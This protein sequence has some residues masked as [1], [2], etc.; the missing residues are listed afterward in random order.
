MVQCCRSLG[1][2]GEAIVLR[3]FGPDRGA[4]IT[5]GLQIIDSL[6]CEGNAVLPYT[7]DSL[8]GIATFLWNLDLLEA[9][10][11]LQ[12][13]NSSQSKKTTFLRE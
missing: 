2:I 8:D 7:F 11:N 3:Q 4:L 6:R 5:T 9:L 10:A 1:C 13:F 12:F